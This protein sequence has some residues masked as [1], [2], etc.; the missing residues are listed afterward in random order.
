MD[1]FLQFEGMEELSRKVVVQLIQSIHVLGKKNLRITFN[2]N[3]EYQEAV[4]ALAATRQ[5]KAG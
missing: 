4:E 3:D 2:Y 1:R 5:R